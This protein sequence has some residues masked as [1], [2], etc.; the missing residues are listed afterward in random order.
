MNNKNTN[1]TTEISLLKSIIEEKNLLVIILIIFSLLS[2]YFSFTEQTKLKETNTQAII[3]APY[4]DFFLITEPLLNSQDFYDKINQYSLR[5][6]ILISSIDKFNFDLSL[7]LTSVSNL[8]YFLNQK[9]NS[10]YLQ[11]LIKNGIKVEEYFKGE[12][13]KIMN[14]DI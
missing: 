2:I 8:N 11:V 12:N 14:K 10:E 6:D 1:N 7:S 5:K 13:L 4:K 9:I 3:R